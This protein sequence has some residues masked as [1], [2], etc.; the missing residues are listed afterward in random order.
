VK[1]PAIN[2]GKFWRNLLILLFIV[3]ITLFGIALIYV[4]QNQQSII[5]TEIDTINQGYHGQITIGSTH[6]APFKNFPYLSIRAHDVKV[7]E[8]K[9]PEAPSILEVADVYAGLDLIELIKGK[10]DIK[11]L[12]IEDGFFDMILYEDGSDNLSKAFASEADTS[13]TE[14]LHVHLKSIELRNFE[15]RKKDR[16][17][18]LDVQGRI[19]RAKGG[20]ESSAQRMAAHLDAE[21]ELNII[22][23]GD[24]T[25][26]KHKQ[27][28]LHTD[29]DYDEATRVMNIAPSEIQMGD[30]DFE[31]LGTVDFKN[32]MDLDL[33]IKG[34][35]PNF[36]LLIA[37]APN[38]LIPVLKRYHNAGN[39]YF[40]AMIVGPA[41]FG[42]DPFIDVHFGAS[43]S[44]LENTDY[45]RRI[46]DLGFQGSFTNGIERNPSSM[47]FSLQNM[48]AKLDQGDLKGAIHVKNFK[49]PEIDMSID[50]DFDLNFI[51]EFLNLKE[52]KDASGSVDLKMK[53]H[54]IVDLDHPEQTLSNLNQAYYSELTIKNLKVNTIDLPAPL[55]NLNAHVVMEGREAKLDQFELRIGQSDLSVTGYLSDVPALLH[56]TQDSVKAHLDI[57]SSVLDL[58]ELTGHAKAD[59]LGFKETIKDLVLGLSFESTARE[60]TRFKYIPKGEFFVDSLTAKME[61]YPHTLHDFHIDILIDERD[62]Y[63]KDF[64]GY[65]DDSDFRIGGKIHDYAFW[66]QDTLQGDVQVD[67]QLDS[68]SLR[69]ED[70]FTYQGV[71]FVPPGYRHEVFEDLKLHINSRLHY[72]SSGLQSFEGYL[73]Q[74]DAKMHLHPM[75]FQ[76]VSGRFHYENERL[77]LEDFHAQLGR[78]IF[79]ID[80]SYNFGQD[81]IQ[82]LENNF[83]TLQTNYIDFDELTNFNFAPPQPEQTAKVPSTED[84][85]EHAEA[86]NLYE[87]PFSNMTFDFDIEHFIYHRL[88]ISEINANLRTTNDHFLYVD[89][90]RLKAAGGDISMNGYF[91]GS[92]PKRIYLRPNLHLNNVDLDQLLFKFENFGQDV[93]VSENLHGQL[94][95][96]I[97]GNIRV[98]PDFVP[99]LDQSEVHMD[100]MA[101]NGRLEN[102]DYMLML[103]D[104][105]DDKNLRSVRFDTLQNHIDVVNGVLT[106]PNMTIESTLG[107]MEIS[108]KQDMN[109]N[110]EY[111][112]RIPWSLVKQATLNRVFGGKNKGEDEMG[113]DEIVEV[114][115][116]EKIRYLNLKITGTLEDFKI[117]PGK[118][119]EKKKVAG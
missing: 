29:L 106:I 111:Y 21:F 100:I 97:T 22:K 18:G 41:A 116:K 10:V 60:L 25:F 119:K 13:A 68:E 90:L 53:F 17:N 31:L 88:D 57:Q 35:K 117:S 109:D 72:N 86:Y 48:S 42:Y 82:G 96:T 43:E 84:V 52:Y 5:Q 107:H 103:S 14:P 51:A 105:F 69:L 37:F 74:F 46:D 26:V 71:N 38:E 98:Y 30:A 73:D 75:R 47:E 80:L 61:H 101:L 99:D 83:L 93:I 50:A 19:F 6:L 1:G 85:K 59:S 27:F 76:D 113:E 32:H 79:N 70:V 8:S 54:D 36:E 110:I 23:N 64:I 56:Q 95:A 65:L 34:S 40:N 91:N 112:V 77:K 39:I 7:L 4:L 114:D 58:A 104:Y 67:I 92:D 102:Y 33:E 16:S 12:T 24:T 62:M 15:I 45:G 108:G 3:P 49:A 66:M 94:S 20:F 9:L 115:P 28:E 89:T 118:K 44:F 55:E 11:K 63:I 2:K 81:S 87:L 78:S